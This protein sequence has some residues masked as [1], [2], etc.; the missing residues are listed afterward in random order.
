MEFEPIDRTKTSR[1]Q[2]DNE[3]L[4]VDLL[5]TAPGDFNMDPG[6]NPISYALLKI[7]KSDATPVLLGALWIADTGAAGFFPTSSAGSEGA[8]WEGIWNHRQLAARINYGKADVPWNARS[9]FDYWLQQI[10][11]MGGIMFES[12]LT[13]NYEEIQNKMAKM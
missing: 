10:S 13:G 8:D 1:M 11:G 7:W 5:Y 4:V 12:E 9:W 2:I 6:E 3:E